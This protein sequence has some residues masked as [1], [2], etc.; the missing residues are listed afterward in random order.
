MDKDQYADAVILKAFLEEPTFNTLRTK[1]QLGYIVR[2][3]LTSHLRLLSFSVLVQSSIKDADFLEHRIN[4]FLAGLRESWDPT[5]EEVETIKA[6]QINKL[7]QKRTSL[8]TEAMFNWGEINTDEYSFDSDQQKIAAIE[9]VTKE[10]LLACFENVFFKNPRRI[11]I[12]THSH[13]H[14]DDTVTREANQQLNQTFYAR[15]DLF[16]SGGLTTQN[17]ENPRSF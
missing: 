14:R 16:G 12:K 11:N 8:G 5:P 10:R 17:I 3:G 7:K 2:A 13:G 4:E 6:A 9:R 15:E 1:E